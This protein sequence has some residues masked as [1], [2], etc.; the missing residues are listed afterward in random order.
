MNFQVINEKEN[1]LFKRKEILISLDY[2]GGSTPSKADFQKTLAEHFKVNIDSV[3]IFK[4]IS[5]NGLPRG[6]AWIKIWQDKKVPIYA[7]L[8][9]EK[10]ETEE[11]PKEV[12]KETPA[13]QP[14]EEV[15]E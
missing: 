13:E 6:K 15:K 14:K 10:K 11:Q 7:E 9:K 3:E 8:K 4:I 5:E 12:P 1:P 2:Q